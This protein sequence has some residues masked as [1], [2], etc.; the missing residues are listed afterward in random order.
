VYPPP[1]IAKYVTPHGAGNHSGRSWSNAYTLQ[2]MI[3]HFSSNTNYNL[4]DSTFVVDSIPI[5]T[6]NSISLV[7]KG[8]N[9]TFIQGSPNGSDPLEWSIKGFD[10]VNSDNITIKNIQIRYFRGFGIRVDAA[11]SYFYSYNNYI[12]SCGWAAFE[13]GTQVIGSPCGVKLFG[14]DAIFRKSYIMQSGWDGMQI[15]GYRTFVDSSVIFATGQDFP[16]AEHQ[17]DG[18][19]MFKNPDPDS[20]YWV[21]YNGDS[22]QVFKTGQAIFIACNIN[23]VVDRKSGIEGGWDSIYYKPNNTPYKLEKPLVQVKDCIVIGGKGIGITQDDHP[24]VGHF[25]SKIENCKIGS[26]DTSRYTCRLDWA[27][28]LTLSTTAWIKNNTFYSPL[29]YD[30]LCPI[31]EYYTDSTAVLYSNNKWR[32]GNVDS[33]FCVKHN[34]P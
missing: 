9:K 13:N 16:D 33:S 3:D 11:S 10:L 17:G 20:S 32:L 29:G 6:R 18:V 30:N 24:R 12:D 1:N 21:P 22:I 28:A 7:G 26:L 25:S 5:Y 4:I 8:I 23:T 31:G 27:E 19:H 34:L 14:D 2:E 15:A